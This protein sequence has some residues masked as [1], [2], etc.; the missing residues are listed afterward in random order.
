MVFN[1]AENPFSGL[2][3]LTFHRQQCTLSSSNPQH[4][5]HVLGSLKI[6][7]GQGLNNEQPNHVLI[8]AECLQRP[9]PTAPAL[10]FQ[11]NLMGF[12]ITR[13]LASHE[14]NEFSLVG[15]NEGSLK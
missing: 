4:S 1:L 14:F 11:Q 8:L 13:G 2:D 12:L 10:Q 6:R 9:R 3:F 5:I 15:Q 7:H